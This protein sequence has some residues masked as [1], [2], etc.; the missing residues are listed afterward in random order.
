M[1]PDL[2]R[3]VTDGALPTRYRF[4]TDG[5]LNCDAL[6][7][8]SGRLRRLPVPADPVTALD[9]ANSKAFFYGGW[10]SER[11]F[12]LALADRAKCKDPGRFW[13]L[14]ASLELE[15]DLTQAALIEQIDAFLFDIVDCAEDVPVKRAHLLLL[16]MELAG[17]GATIT[18]EELLE[19]ATLPVERAQH[20]AKLPKVTTT[21]LEHDLALL[22]YDAEH[23]VR[24]APRT[25]GAGLVLIA[26]DSGYGKSWRLAAMLRNLDRAGHLA[27]LVSNAGSL[28]TIRQR[29]VDLVWHS[30]FDSQQSMPGLQRRLGHRFVDADGVWLTVGVDDV[31]DR[32]LLNAM[33]AANWEQ[34]GVRLVATVPARLAEE[35]SESPLPPAIVPVE[36]FSLPQVRRF[37]GSHHRR[38]RDL[39]HDVLELLQTPIFADLYR[40]IGTAD[41][42]PVDEYALLDRFWR[43]TTYLTKGM[44]DY[45]DDP[46]ALE[47]LARTLITPAGRYPW[48]VEAAH[49]ADLR[50]DARKRL[51]KSGILRQGE[52]GIV[53]IHDRVL[54]WAVARAIAADLR[55]GA[56]GPDEAVERLS[57]LDNAEL[58]APGL[59]YRL[60]YVLL[61]FLWLICREAAAPV[62]AQVITG[63]LARPGH[64]NNHGKFIEEHLAGLGAPILP[65]LAL[66]AAQE[67]KDQRIVSIQ[68]AEGIA[69]LGDTDRGA[70]ETVVIGLLADDESDEAM[71]AGLIAAARVAVPGAIDRLW[72]I[73]LARRRLSAAAAAAKE[74]GQARY[75]LYDRAQTSFKA[76]KAAA[77]SR[78]VWIEAK[79]AQTTDE[80]TA[81][82]LL[83]LLGEVEHGAGRD[84]WRRHKMAFLAR[85]AAGKAIIPEAIKH[86]GDGD[87]AARLEQVST[88]PDYLEPTRRF[89]ALV[90]VA[91]GRAASQISALASHQLG[92][93]S[94]FSV[95]RL[96]RNGGDA[97]RAAL[98]ARH[99]PGW[100]GMADLAQTY[101]HDRLAIDAA[102]FV[103]MI[104]ALEQ[105]LAE[106]AGQPWRPARE[107][108]LVQ[109]LAETTR[110][111]LLAIFETY[112]GSNLERLLRDV[113]TGS[114]GRDSRCVDTDADHIGR[115]LLMIGGEGY[116]EMVS[117]AIGRKRMIARHDGYEAAIH[118]PRG[119]VAAGLT[120]AVDNDDRHKQES[121]DLTVA[122][123]VHGCDEGLYRLIMESQAPF[124]DAIDV[125]RKQGSWSQHVD[126][127]MRADLASADSATRSGAVC[128]LAMAPPEDAID[129]LAATLA[130]CPDADPSALTV[131]R[132]SAHLGLY[133]PAMLPQLE[134]MLGLALPEIREAVLP[135]LAE[136][137]DA[138]ARAVALRALSAGAAG[139]FDRATLRAAYAL[140]RFE[141]QGG[142]ASTRLLP[143]VDRHHGIYPTGVIARRL[144]ENG[145]LSN[146][147][148]IDLAYSAK[149][150]SSDCV[151]RLVDWIRTFDREE[152]LAIAERRFAQTPSAGVAR[153]ILELGG[154]DGVD[155][156]I[157]AYLDDHRHEVRW[158]IARALRRH[159]ERACI[160][161]RLTGLAARNTV[162]ARVVAAELLGWI[163]AEQAATLVAALVD[164]P[165]TAV[166][167]AA[168]AA[169]RRAEA[170]QWGRVLICEI[171]GAGH[172][173]R[174][175]RIQA[176]VDL[177]DP[178]LLELDGDRDGLQIG[179]LVEGLDEIVAIWIEK[180]LVRRKKALIS[181]AEQLDRQS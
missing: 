120:A 105:R 56:I 130:R 59:A 94:W 52:A 33:R 152:A 118:L 158:L 144:H 146:E 128:A 47:R 141:P 122:L 2:L 134:R 132:I 154:A 79:L 103:A 106:R 90:R 54:N 67:G 72:D 159:G 135:F 25:S 91:P 121:Y 57:R 108:A 44:A 14:L 124:D 10:K 174:W 148:L 85:I 12:F 181:Q 68:A 45:Q 80:L 165:V 153:Q 30:S 13:R 58:V 151:F 142:P 24:E 155:H 129:L 139:Q 156:L 101:W 112:R 176:L 63:L 73:H 143:F 115:L 172:L 89:D 113:A 6:L 81:I 136:H 88:D 96:V 74:D 147:A 11:A 167:D 162:S 76:L 119:D 17:H 109:F 131:V 149:G 99:P 19:K 163:P 164:D 102:S 77:I 70:V 29:V 160:I 116:G 62:V 87:E 55:N 48:T 150:M 35:I 171:A 98:L 179:D 166:S 3:A 117:C 69:A 4:V 97:V 170:E 104:G 107:R 50:Q 86:F 71:R 1:I 65:V 126:T 125:R 110:P 28:D 123:A 66:L 175:S 138:A 51:V 26:G 53:V 40:R 16:M 177:V 83:E 95:Q 111:D 61:D 23:D 15:G 82:L 169:E 34:Y 41:W 137:G 7:E 5:A 42:A 9:D 43:H 178:Y 133:A 36:R 37:L 92:W 8:L 75:D 27:V 21:A 46:L 168:L 39:P 60:G 20:Y 38:L 93:R 22:G 180:A 64:R 140:S 84:L 157:Q 114:E 145:V 32:D 173:G 161:A 18:V 31:Q 49:I 78:P 100:E 127:W